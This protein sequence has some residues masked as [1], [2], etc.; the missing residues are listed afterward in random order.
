MK[1][2]DWFYITFSVVIFI[3]TFILLAEVSDMLF[4]I[5]CSVFS[6]GACKALI[7]FHFPWEK[8]EC[9]G[10]KHDDKF[11]KTLE[12][13]REECKNIPDAL[14]LPEDTKEELK[15]KIGDIIK[16]KETLEV[17]KP[18]GTLLVKPHTQSICK[19]NTRK[20]RR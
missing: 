1:R 18:A 10:K 4:R 11:P 3:T 2:I 13:L 19:R 5:L 9:C 8:C 14:V 7:G 16:K 12:E 20:R 6:M 17:S 15:E